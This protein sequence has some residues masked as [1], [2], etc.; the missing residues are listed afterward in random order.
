MLTDKPTETT[1]ATAAA[2]NAPE[3][4]D[5]DALTCYFQGGYV[6]MRDAKISIMTHAFMYGTAVFEGIR[7]YWNAEQS[8]LYGVFLREHV[9]RIR[10][11]AGSC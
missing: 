6:P 7:A 4:F 3:P 8:Q 10:T 5:L 2:A 11:A 9:E 1:T